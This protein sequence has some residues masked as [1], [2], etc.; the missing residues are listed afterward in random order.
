MRSPNQFIVRPINGERYKASTELGGKNFITSTSE[1]DHS[2]SNRLAEVVSLPLDHNGNIKVGDTLLVHHNV[3]KFYNDMRGQRRS[4]KSFFKDDLFF[5]DTEQFFMWHDGEKW[6]AYDRHCFIEPIDKTE[7]YL[8]KPFLK[9]PLIGIMRYPSRAL[10]MLG[11]QKGA[12]VS[13]TPDS[14]YEFDVD[15]VKM[16]RIHDHQ[17]T[18]THEK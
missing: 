11:I 13:F 8:Y 5:V 12:L 4:G 18:M 7:S 17:I 6:N 10:E 15:G 16:Y 3:F 2:A 9:E 14:E 1:E